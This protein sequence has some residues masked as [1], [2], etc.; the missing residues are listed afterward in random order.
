MEEVATLTAE[1]SPC[2]IT[3]TIGNIHELKAMRLVVREVQDDHLCLLQK[4]IGYCLHSVHIFVYCLSESTKTLFHYYP[5]PLHSIVTSP[6]SVHHHTT[7]F[8]P[9]SP[10]I[11]LSPSLFHCHAHLCSTIT[12][13]LLSPSYLFTIFTPSLLTLVYV[14]ITFCSEPVGF[15]DVLVPSYAPKQV[16]SLSKVLTLY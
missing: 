15:L 14:P 13:F 6:S 8:H 10:N 5:F 16:C 11:P 2:I 4:T 7:L 9:V 1:S 3:P 12:L